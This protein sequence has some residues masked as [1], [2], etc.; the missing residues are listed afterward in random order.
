[1][2]DYNYYSFVDM[3]EVGNPVTKTLSEQEILD[4]FYQSWY[5]KMVEKFGKEH[6]DNTYSKKECIEDW[7]IIHYAYKV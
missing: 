3:D 1:M 2:S 7:C 5:N 6:V 4:I